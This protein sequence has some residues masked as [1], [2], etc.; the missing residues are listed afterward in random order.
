MM[1]YDIQSLGSDEDMDWR[2]AS[3]ENNN[4]ADSIDNQKDE[5]NTLVLSMK[6]NNF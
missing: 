3:P 2:A 4:M 5:E 1:A 6:I